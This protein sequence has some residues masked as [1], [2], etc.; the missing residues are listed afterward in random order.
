MN[1]NVK[2]IYF[3]VFAFVCGCVICLSYLFFIKNWEPQ[4]S[5]LAAGQYKKSIEI[6]PTITVSE[7]SNTNEIKIIPKKK[8]ILRVFEEEPVL[9]EEEEID[10][11]SIIAKEAFLQ[12]DIEDKETMVYMDIGNYD[13][14]RGSEFEIIVNLA[15]PALA[16]FSLMMEFDNS[17]LEYVEKSEKA[18]GDMF[19]YGIEFYAQNEQGRMILISAGHPGAKHTEKVVD[20]PVALF[21][22]K[23]KKEGTTKITFA[24]K[25]VILLDPFGNKMEYDILGGEIEIR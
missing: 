3:S 7:N 10:M 15:A 21:R 14:D 22:M 6:E 18:I 12:S 20:K 19:R 23:A 9:E 8:K 4:Q 5:E 16:N 1:Q 24:E 2:F 17:Y 11:A 13:I 25:G